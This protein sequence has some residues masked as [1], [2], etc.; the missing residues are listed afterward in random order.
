LQ[1]VFP[2]KEQFLVVPRERIDGPR[3]PDI[4]VKKLHNNTVY[5]ILTIENKCFAG[6]HLEYNW[7][8]ALADL[9]V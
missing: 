7:K 9:A 5:T 8:S 6:W 2:Y 4:T 1:H 3:T